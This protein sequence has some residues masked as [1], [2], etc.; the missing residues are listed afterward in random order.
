MLP[1]QDVRKSPEERMSDLLSRMTVEE[2]I[3][4]LVKMDGFRSYTRQGEDFI[5]TERF[6]AFSEK[7]I[8]GTMSVLL[9]ADWWT[10]INWDNGI[11]P[12]KMRT[13]VQ[14]FQKFVYENSRLHIPLYIMEEASHGL[15]ALGSTVFPTGIGL[16]A[17]WDC[18]MMKK[19]GH[20]VGRECAAAGVQAT[21][22]P[23]L[24]VI[25]D[26]RW[27][28]CEE[29]Y[30]EDPEL[31][32]L[33]VEAYLSGL[34]AE[35]IVPTLKH[36][37][38]H[39]SPE[40]GHNHGPAHAGPVE[41]FNCQLRPFRRGIAAG[42][43]SLM[44]S[45]NAVDGEAVSGSF[46]YL[47]EVLRHQMGFDGFV[48]SD[49]GAIPRLVYQRICRT[50]AEAAAIAL[51]A[52]CDVDNGGWENQAKNL[53]DALEQGLISEKDLDVAAGRVLKLKFQLGLFEN[54]YPG[55][56]PVKVLH[57]PEHKKIALDAARKCLTLLKNDGVL[58]LKNIKRIA[59]IGPN[60]DHVMNQLGDYTAPQKEGSVSTIFSG[61][62]EI[63]AEKQLKVLYARG[64][65]IRKNDRSGFDE[66]LQTAEQADVIIF[67]PG[68]S[69]TKYGSGMTRTATGAAV[70]EILSPED[71]EKESGE[72]TDRAT[73]NFS[74]VQMELFDLLCKTGKPVVTVPILGR[75][76]LMSEILERSSAVLLAW[77]PGESGG[78]AVGEVLF[79]KY[80]PAGRLPVSLPRSEGQLPLY[81]NALEERPD[82]VDQTSSPLLPFGFGLSYTSFSYSN[83]TWNGRELSVD[84]ANTGNVDGEEVVQFYLTALNSPVQRPYLELA[85]FERIFIPAGES[86]RVSCTPSQDSLGFHDRHGNFVSPGG[87]FSFHAG[88]DSQTLLSLS[89]VPVGD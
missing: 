3:G 9:R 76:L 38:G 1:Y 87:L 22:G 26:I 21:H 8:P 27:S 48:V 67:V 35:G 41:L 24:D 25:R 52:G 37:C 72:G 83:L 23:V 18:D 31:T 2:K 13:A 6:S 73:L 88:P 29:N 80:N 46:Y 34:Q 62:S 77:Y 68:G 53:T 64:C 59:V 47:T 20:V 57:D 65:S 86:R 75:P 19:I 39:G 42:A 69:S 16:G 51:K 30:A 74:G 61:I 79:G 82:Y 10:Q 11:P 44:S 14:K 15:M 17:M 78:K 4:Q 32:A 45:Y 66:A 84:V 85:G 54:P 56:D 60:A 49:R 12:E 36:F 71:S 5:F 28:R 40:G 81:Y 43:R 63:A 55:S 7:W 50:P 33:Y 89:A 58:P 70:A